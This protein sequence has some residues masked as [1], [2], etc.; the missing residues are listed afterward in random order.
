MENKGPSGNRREWTGKL[1]LAVAVILVVIAVYARILIYLT[2]PGSE[3]SLPNAGLFGDSFGML[4][5][6]FSGLAFA[7]L[8]IAILMQREEL[9]L[10]REELRLTR[11]EMQAQRFE[12]TFFEM[13]RLHNGIVNAMTIEFVETWV[14]E[15][16]GPESKHTPVTGRDCFREFERQLNLHL[17]HQNSILEFLDGPIN[18]AYMDFWHKNQQ[19]LGHYFRHLYRTLRFVHDSDGAN[20][21]LYSGILRAQLS[22]L[23]LKLLYY[24]CFSVYGRKKFK[25][26]A[27]TYALFDNLPIG[28]I[29]RRHLSLYRAEA[30]GANA[31]L[32]SRIAAAHARMSQRTDD[33][34]PASEG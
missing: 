11:N 24:H 12:T 31:E 19:Y 10:Q 29:D 26:L 28:L 15:E 32:V 14:D 2:A 17:E 16:T 13:V 20:K 21:T 8:V 23:E 3:V 5:A 30:W 34:E 1:L 9:Q 7:G 4:N 22:D 18:G 25:P 6:A 33:D 27:E